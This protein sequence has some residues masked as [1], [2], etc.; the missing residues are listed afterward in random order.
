MD[1]RLQ[2]ILGITIV[3]FKFG[4]LLEAGSRPEVSETRPSR[5]EKK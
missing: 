5:A 2:K 3:F 1:A 4:N